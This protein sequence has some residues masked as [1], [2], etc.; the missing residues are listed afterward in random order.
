VVDRA[1]LIKH[2]EPR[3]RPTG[4]QA[5][6][7][8]KALDKALTELLLA[9]PFWAIQ[10]LPPAVKA[11]LVEMVRLIDQKT[12]EKLATVWEPKRKLDTELKGRVKKDIL[13]LIEAKRPA[14]EPVSVSLSEARNG[15]RGSIKAILHSCA[16]TKDL[17]ALTKKWDKNW[18]PGH[19]SRVAYEERLIALIDGA[20]PAAR[21]VRQ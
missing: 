3:V 8:S 1:N 21:A 18:K 15:D 4:S 16:P 11:D 7:I 2:L 20:E 17:K 10:Q 9:L 6:A 14:Y 19:E 13:A 12:C 5:E